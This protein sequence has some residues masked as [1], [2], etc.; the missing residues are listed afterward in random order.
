[1][2]QAVESKE[3]DAEAPKQP[4]NSTP[5]VTKSSHLHLV[6]ETNDPNIRV[7]QRL[8]NA[9]TEQG[10]TLDDIAKQIKFRRE[11]LEAIETMQVSRLPKG[12]VN[13]YIRDYARFLGLDAARCVED[14]NMQ[15]GALSQHDGQPVAA[16]QPPKDNTRLFQ[17]GVTLFIVLLMAVGIWF[18]FRMINDQSAAPV[19]TTTGPSIAITPDMNGA[20]KSVIQTNTP[21]VPTDDTLSLEIRAN[22][23]AWIEIRGADGTVFFDRR[24]AKDKVYSVRVGAG[25]TLTTPNAGA[26][27]WVVN[28][29]V[30]QKLGDVDQAIY[31]LSID[32]FAATL[33]RE[34]D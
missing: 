26:F 8:R 33:S 30:T 4:V 10:L 34:E 6:D 16:A 22:E 9:R 28:G 14:F 15:C 18:G 7:G 25:W 1:M 3:K 23:R 17:L 31:S 12:L 21:V 27:D 2:V 13:P 32:E 11:Y 24:L 5:E 20:D 19:K 29:E